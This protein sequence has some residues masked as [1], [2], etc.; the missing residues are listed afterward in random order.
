MNDD[1]ML[2]FA[3]AKDLSPLAW[4]NIYYPAY[5]INVKYHYPT[6]N[7][8]DFKDRALL[9]LINC[10][11]PYETAC[12]I[13]GI[14]DPHRSILN[15]FVSDEKQ[16]LVRF[17][18][19]QRQYVLT[20]MGKRKV[21]GIE[22]GKEGVA[23]CYI[24]GYTGTPFPKAVIENINE[25]RFSICGNLAINPGGMYPFDAGIEQKVQALNAN[26]NDGNGKDYRK[27]LNLSDKSNEFNITLL[28]Q[29]WISNLS[30]GVF[31]KGSTVVRS[32]FGDKICDEPTVLPPFGWLESLHQFK[33]TIN[34]NGLKFGYVKDAPTSESLFVQS[35]DAV[36]KAIET[37]IEKTY[38]TEFAKSIEL[39]IE[40]KSGQ[41]SMK[42]TSLNTL[43]KDRAKM[44]DY[45]DNG[46]LPLELKG[47]KG[48]IFL[49]LDVSEN[50]VELAHL[51]KEINSLTDD[52][53]QII[54]KVKRLYPNS[55]R[56]TLLTI[57]RHDLLF[58]YD[59]EQF[60]N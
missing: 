54:A 6:S 7:P 2:K 9:Q 5:A 19:R 46:I 20:P 57:D 33:L 1:T 3:K 11:I 35:P 15:R 13:L 8:D 38:G 45:I 28:D 49:K 24:D 50:I 47:I 44:L 36:Y 12:E 55:W 34:D 42:I 59:V 17:D 30:I 27:R 51:S 10:K 39:C 26:L 29:K 25:Q 40:P 56:Q 22:L 48:T 21:E 43:T 60:I 23:C 32:V 53:H 18:E 58:R 31:L 14:R 16:A 4:F 41:C 52:W 37:R